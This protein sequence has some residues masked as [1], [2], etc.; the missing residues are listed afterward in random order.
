MS[1]E[2]SAGA[3]APEAHP[4]RI[5]LLPAVAAAL[6]ILLAFVALLAGTGRLAALL[7]CDPGG[8]APCQRVLFVGNSYTSVNDLPAVFRELA[9]SGGHRVETGT[10]APGGATLA[11]HAASA[12]TLATIAGS[13]WQ[14]VVLQE[15]S[16]IPSVEG[17][18]QQGMYPAARALVAAARAAG[19]EPVFFETWAY[20]GGWP[21]NGLDYRAMQVQID[22]GY[23]AIAAELGVL[24]A[25]VGGA[26]L[27]L[28]QADPALDLWQDDGSH[29]DT[30]GTY[31]AAC[32]FYATIFGLSPEG[33]GYVDGLPPGVARTLQ[34]MAATVVGT[35]SP[36]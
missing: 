10:V 7:P 28:R 26:W 9:R 2:R 24:V 13:R 14:Y 25:P 8:T 15:Q 31:L 27:N 3:S 33:A 5:G 20:R 18:R 17:A 4:R 35:T 6:A 1:D 29:P 32:V 30:A 11:Q 34:H 23:G 12:D 16:Q 19:A 21:E 22:A 36:G